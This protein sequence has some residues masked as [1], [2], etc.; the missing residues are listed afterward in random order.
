[1]KKIPAMIRLVLIP[2]TTV[3][4]STAHGAEKSDATRSPRNALVRVVTVSQEGLLDKPGRPRLEATLKRLDRAASFRPDI[5]CLPETFTRGDA[6]T[7]PGP[8][9]RRLSAWV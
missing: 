2:A 8:A 4:M 5:V 6:E 1:M 7:V 9:T 3:V